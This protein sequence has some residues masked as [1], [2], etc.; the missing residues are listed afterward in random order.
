MQ[1]VAVGVER[2]QPRPVIA[3]NPVENSIK[4]G[5]AGK[6]HECFI[7]VQPTSS[8]TGKDH[9]RHAAFA[10]ACHAALR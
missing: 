9:Q 7:A 10:L 5:R 1:L 8:S 2:D 6:R 4:Q 3:A